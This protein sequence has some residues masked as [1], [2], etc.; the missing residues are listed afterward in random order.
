MA[1]TVLANSGSAAHSTSSSTWTVALSVGTFNADDWII[2]NVATDNIST[3]DGNTNDHVSIDGGDGLTWYKIYEYTNGEGAAASGVTVSCW[4]ARNTTGSVIGT[5]D[6]NVTFSGA[7]VDKALNGIKVTAGSVLVPVATSG[8]ATD[9]SANFGSATI[10]G[11]ASA[12]YLYVRGL[13]KEVNST[14]QITPSSS[15]TAFSTVRSRSN[16]NAI[17][18][19]GEWRINTSTGETSDPTQVNV[20]DTAGIFF[21]LSES[22]GASAPTLLVAS[23]HSITSTY[24]TPRVT[25]TR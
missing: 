5:L 15:F 20:G 14:A 12:E 25:F 21:A 13:T 24:A 8:N 10:S 7:C 16:A 6:F 23:A 19:R 3:T 2:I 18:A 17:I 22:A 1:I 4:R 11:L 9:A